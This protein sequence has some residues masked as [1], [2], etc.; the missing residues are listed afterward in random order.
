MAGPR[1]FQRKRVYDAERELFPVEEFHRPHL[2]ECE[3]LLHRMYRDARYR[4]MRRPGPV[5][6]S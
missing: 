2:W 6:R 1:D 5:C 4:D 3:Q